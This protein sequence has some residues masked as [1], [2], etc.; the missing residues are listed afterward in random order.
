MSLGFATREDAPPAK[1]SVALLSGVIAS[2][3][4]LTLT[5]PSSKILRF[6]G[7][8]VS[9]VVP[10]LVIP[11]PVNPD[12]RTYRFLLLIATNFS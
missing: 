11:A 4:L 5:H 3:P 12:V 7:W 2:S 9:V 10:S 1:E 6:L 8:L